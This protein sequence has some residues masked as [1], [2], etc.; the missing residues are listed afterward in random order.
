MVPESKMSESTDRDRVISSIQ[1]SVQTPS[2]FGEEEAIAKFFADLMA[3][4]GATKVEVREVEPGR[5]N[6]IGTWDTGLP[7]PRIALQGHMDTVPVGEHPEPF[8]GEIRDGA[9]YGRGAS[10]MKGPLVTAALAA[11]FAFREK[12]GLRGSCQVVCTVDEE[13]EKRGIFDIVDAG[14]EADFGICVEPTD[15]RVAIAQKGCVS[16]R[17]TTKGR[18]SHGANPQEGINAISKMAKVIQALDGMELPTVDIPGVGPVSG[19][20]SIGVIEGGSMFFI[21]PD[22]CSIWIDRRTVPGET[23]SEAIE[24]IEEVVKSVDPEAEVVKERQD[25]NWKRIQDR[26]IGSCSVDIESPVV[27]AVLQG[28]ESVTGGPP[29]LHVQNA[30][31]ETDFFVNDL[32]IPTVNLGPGKMELA[33]T[34]NEHIDIESAVAGAQIL[35]SAIRTVLSDDGGVS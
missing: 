18:A 5:P 25:W 6:V 8:S 23:Q 34:S 17:V 13:S 33:H 35:T 21:V 10:D 1:K 29:E 28:V 7:G 31:C 3:E 26:G 27:Q 14:L 4:G 24:R 11:E 22:R 9:I 12:A 32:G 30:W 19:T 15:L 2:V 16:V 20:L